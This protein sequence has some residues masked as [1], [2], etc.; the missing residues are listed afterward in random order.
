MTTPAAPV[1]K[2][3]GSEVTLSFD[4]PAGSNVALIHVLSDRQGKQ[5]YDAKVAG[6]LA[7]GKSGKATP[8]TNQTNS[9]RIKNLQGDV[10]YTATIAFR[11]AEDIDWGPTSP[12]S[13][14][15]TI[16]PPVAPQ[17]P[18]LEPV[19]STEIRVT[20]VAPPRCGQVNMIFHDGK[21]EQRVKPDLTL[22]PRVVGG[23][24]LSFQQSKGPSIIVK[25]L[26]DALSYK[27][28][29][30]GHNGCCWGLRGPW[31]EPLKL[32]DHP[33]PA[34]PCAP[35]LRATRRATRRRRC[36]RRRAASST[37]RRRAAPTTAPSRAARGACD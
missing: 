13:A 27:V 12:A 25:G 2:F 4:A 11:G 10:A 20:F 33:R 19:S 7:P 31:S 34:P 1:L 14:T 37:T 18:L 21:S 22:G 6:V 17:A 15:L 23:A 28:A 3:D 35:F 30:R 32:S 16:V 24:C 36:P 5:L 8:L 9:V 26:S 29:L